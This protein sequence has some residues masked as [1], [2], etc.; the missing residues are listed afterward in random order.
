M[1]GVK[2]SNSPLTGRN[3]ANELHESSEDE[4]MEKQSKCR[5]VRVLLCSR[6]VEI[7]RRNLA[8]FS[9]SRY[10]A[11][12]NG[13]QPTPHDQ[14]RKTCDIQPTTDLSAE[15]QNNHVPETDDERIA[16]EHN[17]QLIEAADSTVE[18]PDD[19]LDLGSIAGDNN[20]QPVE[21]VG[22]PAELTDDQSAVEFF[23][24]DCNC[25]NDQSVE[26]VD[27]MSSY[28]MDVGLYV[29]VSSEK[30][31]GPYDSFNVES[32]CVKQNGQPNG[33]DESSSDGSTSDGSF[34]GVTATDEAAMAL[35]Q[36]DL[37]D[38]LVEKSGDVIGPLVYNTTVEICQLAAEY[39]YGRAVF[40]DIDRLLPRLLKDP[41][42]SVLELNALTM[43]TRV[44]LAVEYYRNK[45]DFDLDQPFTRLGDKFKCSSD[46][47]E[48][49]VKSKHSLEQTGGLLLKNYTLLVNE[50]HKKQKTN[51]FL[52]LRASGKQ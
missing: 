35:N 23:A 49:L 45:H 27:E 18:M 41:Y 43:T 25:I 34:Y 3:E 5:G 47:I 39:N 33:L 10:Y 52:H 29:E 15:S 16:V 31:D 2:L 46:D 32:S 36:L 22:L 20:D 4:E 37:I 50:L 30:L 7:Y 11:S 13:G 24:E 38:Q 26:V 21:A 9:C 1:N 42:I 19:Q 17:Y 44:W 6:V 28:H 8:N 14:P 40:D 12:L 48:A 51:R